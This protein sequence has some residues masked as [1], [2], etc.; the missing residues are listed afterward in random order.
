MYKYIKSKDNEQI[1][2]ASSL[3][4][5]KYRK[6][7]HE[8]LCEGY[9]SLLMAL[10]SKI[11]KAIFVTEIIDDIDEEIPQFI[12]SMDL[13]KKI[14]VNKNPEGVVFI[15]KMM[16]FVDKDFQK[17]VYLDHISDPGNMG[18][19][20]RTA[21]AFSYDA[22]YLSEGCVDLYNEKVIA[23][24]KGAIFSIPVI[25]KSI[26]DIKDKTP[27][28]VSTLSKEAIDVHKMPKLDKFCLVIGNESHGVS[29]EIIEQS[30]YQVIIPINNIDSLNASIAAGILIEILR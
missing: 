28:I 18:T 7:Y 29:K 4:N 12:V 6:L 16:D 5:N 9:K 15:C 8:F 10:S 22:V 11:V 20:I 26:S 1:K 30:D 13:L 3:L 25:K 27:I 2:H 23:A 14:S 24:S 17:V 19:I 21:L